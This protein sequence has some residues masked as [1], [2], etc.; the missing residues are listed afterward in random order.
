MS[1]KKATTSSSTAREPASCV[2]RRH[3]LEMIGARLMQHAEAVDAARQPLD[4]RWHEL[5]DL[6]RPLGASDDQQRGDR[7]SLASRRSVKRLPHG[8]AGPFDRAGEVLLGAGERHRCTRRPARQKAVGGAGARVG[9]EEEARHAAQ[10]S[11]QHGRRRDV[12]SRADDDLGA[13]RADE[14]TPS[15]RREQQGGESSQLAHQPLTDERRRVE[16]DVGRP[17][18]LHERALHPRRPAGPGHGPPPRRQHLGDRETGEHVTGA[19]AAGEQHVP[20]SVGGGWLRLRF[21][22]HS[23]RRVETR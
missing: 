17:G 20:L 7:P 18:A 16:G 8:R 1:S 22:V 12:A 14:A 9:L 5:V 13:Q 19:A 2:V 11:A 3:A 4:D 21:I 10:A 15:P 6:K 23:I